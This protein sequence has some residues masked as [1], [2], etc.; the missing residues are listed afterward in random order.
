MY[1]MEVIIVI[2]YYVSEPS[3]R[4]FLLKVK[5]VI[6]IFFVKLTFK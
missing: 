2:E 6:I 5:I 1:I 3:F 4:I